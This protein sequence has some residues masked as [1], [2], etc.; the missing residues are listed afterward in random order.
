MIAAGIEESF[1]P[2]LFTPYRLKDVT[3]R[4]RVA[5]APMCQYSAVDGFDTDWH[6]PHYVGMA[7]GGADRARYRQRRRGAGHPD[8]PRRTQG[9]RQPSLGGRR[10]HP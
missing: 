2:A 9:Q 6:L 4:N 7:R 3:L 5:V 1:M 10:P 8:R